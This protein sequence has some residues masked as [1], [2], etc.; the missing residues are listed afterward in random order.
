MSY[1]FFYQMQYPHWQQYERVCPSMCSSNRLD[2]I[3]MIFLRKETEN[4]LSTVWLT[5]FFCLCFVKNIS[6]S[7]SLVVL[8][9]SSHKMVRVLV[10]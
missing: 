3:A 8:Y 5:Q 6:A 7:R 4:C 1:A 10:T 9:Q 2:E